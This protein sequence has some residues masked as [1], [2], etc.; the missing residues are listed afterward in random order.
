MNDTNELP[1]SV[2]SEQR[3]LGALFL[4]GAAALKEIPDLTASDFYRQDHKVLFAT[5]T[6]LIQEGKPVDLVTVTEKAKERGQLDTVGGIAYITA[7]SNSVPTAANIKYH[8]D[9][10]KDKAIRRGV[11]QQ[12]KEIASKATDNTIT[13]NDTIS[14]LATFTNRTQRQ[15]AGEY[16]TL[17][18]QVTHGEDTKAFYDNVGDNFKRY[19]TGIPTLDTALNGGIGKLC[20]IGAL[21]SLG[22]T[23]LALQIANNIARAGT[24]VLYFALEQTS[25]DLI[26]KAI[27]RLTFEHDSENPV[28]VDELLH[29]EYLPLKKRQ[30][31][32]Y[33]IKIY[34][35]EIVP[36]TRFINR[37]TDTITIETV[38]TCITQYY[39]SYGVYPLVVLDYIQIMGATNERQN[40]RERIK[41]IC[42]ELQTLAIEFKIPI[43]GICSLNRDS[44]N[45][46]MSMT[47]FKEAG[48]IEYSSDILLGLQPAGIMESD[49]KPAGVSAN[50]RIVSACI[51]S[52]EPR[53]MQ[54]VILK[55]RGTRPGKP[56]NVLFNAKYNAFVATQED[57][58]A[59]TE[60]TKKPKSK[61]ELLKQKREQEQQTA[62]ESF[63][64]VVK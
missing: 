49:G 41:S 18:E 55:N 4:E 16:K 31:L 45:S 42:H 7:T 15:Q 35:K 53:K 39:D 30:N 3:V 47:S 10:I 43:I 2:E 28:S 1:Q 19:A 56:A 36:R 6:D 40:D 44:Y 13:L 23:T 24:G 11:I 22:K 8:A 51:H 52:D 62:F 5:I 12:A 57:F 27:S 34:D 64:E 26:P 33:A 58:T 60:D 37:G 48:E 54:I 38:K 46:P 17:L 59:I 32:E 9:I 14:E 61:S 21:S 25:L 20:F 63:G 29:P 50:K